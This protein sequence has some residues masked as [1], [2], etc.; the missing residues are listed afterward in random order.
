MNKFQKSSLVLYRGKPAI[1]TNINDKIFIKLADNSEKKIRSKDLTFLYAGPV[2]NFSFL[3]NKIDGDRQLAW[4]LLSSED[5]V[6]I[7]ELAE[8]MF[9]EINQTTVWLAYK[10]LEKK[11]LFYGDCENIS[12]YSAE[13]VE[14]KK[15]NLIKKQETEKRWAEYISRV[16]TGTILEEDYSFLKE[17]E[18][19]AYGK[20][21]ASKTLKFLGIP[22]D[23]DKAL[24]LL[25]KLEIIP[26]WFNPYPIRNN[27]KLNKNVSPFDFSNTINNREDL[28]HLQAYA[29]DDT[30]CIDPDDA[31][32]L[33]GEYIWV[34]IADPTAIVNFEDSNDQEAADR[35]VSY[36]FPEKFVPMLPNEI[37]NFF[38]LGLNETSPAMSIKLSLQKNGKPKCEKIVFS[39][40]KAKQISYE[41][42][43]K[44]IE[45]QPFKTLLNK[46][47][48]F[49]EMRTKAGA[50]NLEIPEVK[51]KVKLPKWFDFD[52]ES[53]INRSNSS[54]SEKPE[55][56]IQQIPNSLSRKLVSEIMQ[57]T[58]TA[59]AKWLHDLKIP[60]P[61]ISQPP[62][63]TPFK[64]ETLP[65]M[66]NLRKQLKRS[67]VHLTPAYHS[68]L[69][70]ESYTRVTSP[71]RRYTDL[72][73]HHQIR[74]YL[75]GTE[76]I[77]EENMLRKMSYAENQAQITAKV[78]RLSCLHWKI[79]YLKQDINKKYTAILV[80]KMGTNG[81]IFIPD[82]SL[83]AKIKNCKNAN[84]GDA[85][86]CTAVP[87]SLESGDLYPIFKF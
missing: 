45:K 51:I 65:E 31:I 55:I 5:P 18:L 53:Y 40:I 85:L 87:V 14:K 33:D 4:E 71:L 34:H 43:D 21:Q 76:L 64:P 80:E 22:Q 75:T 54:A 74:A 25:K 73:V 10:E 28:T 6:S 49:N 20:S 58:G 57:M 29:I 62:P 36:Y 79:N 82:L 59:V 13:E 50:I 32:S 27:L 84:I 30:G 63:E 83:T 78:E 70:L 41:D 37:N 61:Y 42:V 11:E 69:G 2:S 12:A 24:L 8:L 16:K 35:G 17:V 47:T 52:A 26:N 44:L 46:A 7:Q 38:G 48:S 19:L 39:I 72:L 1:I 67:E 81:N 3:V 23:S 68:G 56:H 60:V 9:G 86:S 77:D 15:N 66:F